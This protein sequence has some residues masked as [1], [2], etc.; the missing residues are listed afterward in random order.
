M[1]LSGVLIDRF[2]QCFGIMPLILPQFK[3]N[4]L[5]LLLFFWPWFCFP[6]WSATALECYKCSGYQDT[7]SKDTLKSEQPTETCYPGFDRCMRTWAHRDGITFV[8]NLCNSQLG[9]DATKDVCKALEDRLAGYDCAVGCC[10]TDMCNEGSPVSS[11]LFF[12]IMCAVLCLA[13]LK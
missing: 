13:M 6:F 10:S 11:Y 12:L 8:Q 5:C 9:C 4:C 7:C 2:Y 3:Q 1:S